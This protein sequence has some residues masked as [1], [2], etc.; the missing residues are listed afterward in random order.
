MKLTKIAALIRRYFTLAAAANTTS[1]PANLVNI[2]PGM[3][4]DNIALFGTLGN[5]QNVGA[6]LDLDLIAL[7]GGASTALTLTASQFNSEIIDYTGSAAGGVTITTPTAAQI[8]ANLPNTIQSPGYNTLLY[9]MNDGSGQTVTL[10]AGANVTI[11]GNATIA[12]NTL[13]QFLVSVNVAAGTVNLV[14]MGTQNL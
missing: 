8:I 3:V 9:F 11:S 14:N 1:F 13:R 5:L 10:A 12:N 6:A 4:A 2:P 7:N